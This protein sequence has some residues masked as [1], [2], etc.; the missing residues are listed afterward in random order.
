MIVF[1]LAC[2]DHGHRFEGWFGSSVDFVAQQERGLVTCPQCGSADVIKAP[3]APN[4]GRKGNQIAASSQGP[5]AGAPVAGGALPAKAAAA[6][7][8]AMAQMQAAALKESRWVGESFAETS[9]A[10]HYGERAA[11]IIHGQASAEEAI[12]LIEEGIEVVPLPFP[13]APPGETN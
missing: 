1:D 13:V 12:E 2:Q 8:Q 3:M 6:L 4:L 7:M 5:G 10:I 11:E 9:R